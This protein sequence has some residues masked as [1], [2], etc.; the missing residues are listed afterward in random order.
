MKLSRE[1][2]VYLRSYAWRVFCLQVKE[3]DDYRCVTCNS[4]DDLEVHHRSYERLGAELLSDCYTLCRDCHR[5]I[6]S[7]LRRTRYRRRVLPPLEVAPTTVP[8]GA[9]WQWNNQRKDTPN[10]ATCQVPTHGCGPTVTTQWTV[11]RST[12]SMGKGAL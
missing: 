9:S 12:E 8:S 5:L 3:R 10:A 11:G 4:S 6:T 2:R 7:K 1:Y